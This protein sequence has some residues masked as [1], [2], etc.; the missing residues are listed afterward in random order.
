MVTLYVFYRDS[1]SRATNTI[2]RS[3]EKA[4]EQISAYMDDVLYLFTIIPI[5]HK[6]YNNAAEISSVHYENCLPHVYDM[7]KALSDIP[8]KIDISFLY[9]KKYQYALGNQIK[10]AGYSFKHLH[11]MNEALAHL[12][13]NASGTNTL[14]ISRTLDNKQCLFMISPVKDKN[15]NL[16]GK[17]FNGI[18]ISTIET[19]ISAYMNEYIGNVIIYSDNAGVIL[20]TGDGYQTAD[21]LALTQSIA[22]NGSVTGDNNYAKQLVTVRT[23]HATGLRYISYVPLASVLG[24]LRLMN[25][26]SLYFIMVVII[27]ALILCVFTL[28][29]MYKPLDLLV[30]RAK[31]I[32]NTSGK[33]ELQIIRNTLEGLY[34]NRQE[35]ASI[36]EDNWYILKYR[37]FCKYI[38]H[39]ASDVEPDK[40]EKSE[41]IVCLM[42]IKTESADTDHR[43]I[44]T[45][46]E[47]EK[48]I[49]NML[50]ENRV[51]AEVLHTYDNEIMIV[52]KDAI[53][54]TQ[55]TAKEWIPLLQQSVL[56]NVIC[57]ESLHSSLGAP[58]TGTPS[59]RDSLF[60]ARHALKYAKLFGDNSIVTY[61]EI[62][63]DAVRNDLMVYENKLLSLLVDKKNDEICALI[64]E[65]EEMMTTKPIRYTSNEINDFFMRAISE[66]YVY[67]SSQNI[68]IDNAVAKLPFMT[69]FLQKESISD[70]CLWLKEYYCDLLSVMCNPLYN[71]AAL[72]NKLNSV[73]EYI[74][75]NYMKCLTLNDVAERARLSPSYFSTVFKAQTG[76]NFIDYLNKHRIS[77]AKELI[78]SDLT[79]SQIAQRVGYISVNQMGRH[80]KKYVKTTPSKYKDSLWLQRD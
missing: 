70:K 56:E 43:A 60:S 32:G 18:N 37:E 38:Y 68:K 33:N 34:S 72:E 41:F 75:D 3:N 74:K 55:A 22:G 71:P 13:E 46:A 9:S 62:A 24:D 16:Q 8:G 6:A 36:V 61:S 5:T 47:A 51:T 27:L 50:R 45:L 19:N 14:V 53:E 73:C 30:A 15:L 39:Q 59:I 78:K 67:V 69:G 7:Y 4:L 66:A 11:E 44:Q 1:N 49:A 54:D 64:F 10:N 48:H 17:I 52:F 76:V 57:I 28:R 20:D 58:V 42:A 35:L 63:Y 77:V 2:I 40:S 12:C 21:I 79:I 25:Y 29:R 26:F 23:S 31:D 80:F 65:V